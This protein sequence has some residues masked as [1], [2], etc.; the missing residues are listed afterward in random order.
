MQL[1]HAI[2]ALTGN[3]FM[4]S[5]MALGFL[6]GSLCAGPALGQTIL[7][8]ENLGLAAYSASTV[9]SDATPEKAFDGDFT[10]LWNANTQLGWI[11]VDLGQDYPLATAS[12]TA[13]MLPNTQVTHQIWVSD[14]PIQNDTS[15]ATLAWQFSGFVSAY[16]VLE[17]TFPPN[18][19]ARHVQVRKTEGLSWYGWWEVQ[20][21][22][23]DS[24]DATKE[25][26]LILDNDGDGRAD[27]GDT[28]QYTITI[29]NEIFES[30]ENVL[31]RD[32]PDFNSSL[33]VGSV[34]ATQ[35]TVLMGNASGDASVEVDVG[36]LVAE[37]NHVRGAGE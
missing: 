5:M 33:V 6:L 9:Y 28:V 23:L 17:V 4:R 36:T 11:E 29:K 10:T 24:P 25:D 8:S 7:V 35:G 13:S 21:F 34:T 19:S 32:T 22:A 27:P 3:L 37:D 15:G 2:D 12:L 31:L 18:T 14:Q 1:Y 20:I 16:D 26:Q 30:I